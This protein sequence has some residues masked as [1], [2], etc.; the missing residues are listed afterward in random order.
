MI[1]T[2]GIPYKV[3]ESLPIGPGS[4]LYEINSNHFYEVREHRIHGVAIFH[5]RCCAILDTDIFP[6]VE[7]CEINEIDNV[8]FATREAAVT[9][10]EKHLNNPPY[11]IDDCNRWVSPEQYIPKCN[12]WNKF[13]VKLQTPKGVVKTNAYYD[14]GS[15]YPEDKGFWDGTG[16]HSKKLTNVIAW[17]GCKDWDPEEQDNN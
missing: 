2:E 14:D 10:K 7:N 15:E 16:R 8:F 13:Y 4:I 11:P 6:I 1:R 9:W 12:G 17:I 3:G 5:D